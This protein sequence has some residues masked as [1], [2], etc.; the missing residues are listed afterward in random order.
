MAI[1]ITGVNPPAQAVQVRAI[2][3]RIT[4]ADSSTPITTTSNPSLQVLGMLSKPG[5]PDSPITKTQ[6]TP[7]NQQKMD[8]VE[9]SPAAKA[10]ML[11]DTGRPIIEIAIILN[12]DAK[13][14]E[15]YL[16]AATVAM[17]PAQKALQDNHSPPLAQQPS[18]PV[19]VSSDN[20]A[21]KQQ[22]NLLTQAGKK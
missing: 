16:G 17:Q 19:V 3:P 7:Q 8:T 13:T 11:R 2:Q 10:K 21:E 4:Q 9:L 6:K 5:Q 22:G 12:L 15:S 14:V 18:S 1:S 20:S